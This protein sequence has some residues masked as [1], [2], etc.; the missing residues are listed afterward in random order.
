MTIL[1]AALLGAIQGLTE[2][3]PVSSS[4][5]L[6]LLRDA[7]GIAPE[8]GLAFDVILHLAT[9]LA[10]VIAFRTTLAAL[11]ADVWRMGTGHADR[12][13]AEH[14]RLLFALALGTVPAA[15]LG[16]FLESTLEETFR[17]PRFVAGMLLIGSALLVAGERFARKTERHMSPKVGWWIGWFQALAL[18]PGMSRSGSTIAGGMILGIGRLEAARFSFLLAVPI[19]AASGLKKTLDLV[20]GAETIAVP[21]LV[22]GFITAFLVGWAVIHFFLKYLKNHTLYVF[23]AYRLVLAAVVLF[24]IRAGWG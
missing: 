8:G 4:G 1:D 14:R 24:S 16:V 11:A 7:L 6:I 15:V 9:L 19:I 22:A 17:E 10:I 20:A 2:F 18:L 12:V 13:S 21:E 5:H 3:L 23:A